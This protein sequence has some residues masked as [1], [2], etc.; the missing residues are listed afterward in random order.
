MGTVVQNTSIY[1][2]FYLDC[3]CFDY[4]IIYGTNTKF[5]KGLLFAERVIFG[6]GSSSKLPDN[7]FPS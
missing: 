6:F 3:I 1:G 4:F 7:F 2:I 5:Q